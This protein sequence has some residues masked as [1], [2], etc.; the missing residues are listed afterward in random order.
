MSNYLALFIKYCFLTYSKLAD[1][2]DKLP[3]QD[4]ARFQAVL[5]EGK[6]VVRTTL[7]AAVDVV[8]TF[9]MHNGYRDR[10]AQG[11]VATFVQFPK[12]SLD[13]H[14]GSLFR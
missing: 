6:L 2:T 9:F 1:F 3:Q 11:V 14:K 10:H 5:Q 7:P 12:G 13:H 4:Q 8:D